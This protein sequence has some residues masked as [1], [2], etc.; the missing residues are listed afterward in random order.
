MAFFSSPHTHF[1][2]TGFSH[3]CYYHTHSITFTSARLPFY[4]AI[5]LPTEERN[6]KRTNHWNESTLRANRDRRTRAIDECF[7]SVFRCFFPFCC[8]EFIVVTY[9]KSEF[10]CGFMR[11][12]LR[13]TMRHSALS[14]FLFLPLFCSALSLCMYIAGA[15]KQ[16]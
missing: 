2:H 3:F 4:I 12:V 13:S 14:L 15:S 16:W 5:K 9:L 1:N 6:N 7:S 10:N 8:S 11:K